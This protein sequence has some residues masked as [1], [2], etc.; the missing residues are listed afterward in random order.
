MN[1]VHSNIKNY[2]LW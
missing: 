2:I 1:K